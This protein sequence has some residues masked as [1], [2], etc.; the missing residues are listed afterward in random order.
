MD[1]GRLPKDDGRLLK[2]DGRLPEDDG[3]LPED[4]GR[5]PKDD[6]RLPK[7]GDGGSCFRDTSKGLVNGFLKYEES[8]SL[9]KR[10]G[11]W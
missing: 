10:D 9:R 8:I 3:R 1:D 6:C 11:E 4:D 2:D 7:N 5:L